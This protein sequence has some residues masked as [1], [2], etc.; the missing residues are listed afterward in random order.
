[1]SN[2]ET[3]AQTVIPNSIGFTS[4]WPVTARYAPI[5]A[6]PKPIPKTR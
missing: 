2:P 3:Q 5:G 6:K 4:K 1:M